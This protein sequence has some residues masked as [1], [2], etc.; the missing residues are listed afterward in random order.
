ML[1]MYLSQ[2]KKTYCHIAIQRT[3][4]KDISIKLSVAGGRRTALSLDIDGSSANRCIKLGLSSSVSD[5]A[6]SVVVVT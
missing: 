5:K 1:Q 6:L 2:R 3:L 4:I